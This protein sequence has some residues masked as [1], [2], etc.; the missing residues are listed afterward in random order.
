MNKEADQKHNSILVSIIVPAYNTAEYIHRAIESSLRQT[1]KNVEIVIVDDGSTDDT[2]KIVQEYT[3]RDN[4]VRVFT[5][6]NGGVSSARNHGIREAKGEF[7]IFLDSDDWLEDDAAEILAVAQL[8][9]PDMLI[10]CNLY[11]LHFVDNDS[12]HKDIFLRTKYYS[13]P[14]ME[15][16]VSETI[17]A[18]NISIHVASYAKL[19]RADV[20]RR[21]NLRFYEGIHYG[22]DQL[23]TFEYLIKMKGSF[24]VDKPLFD[25][26]YRPGSS[27]HVAHPKQLKTNSKDWVSFL[28]D[29]PEIP[30]DA[31]EA[32]AAYAAS[33]YMFRYKSALEGSSDVNNILSSRKTARKYLKYCLSRR[34]KSIPKKIYTVLTTYMPIPL[35]RGIL[36]LVRSIKRYRY[37]KNMNKPTKIREVIPYW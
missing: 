6:K 2:L 3:A 13:T 18:Y 23:F 21:Y 4:R 35:A 32:A 1:H 31:R 27:T 16:T 12:S 17:D 37:R 26:L 8:E 7:L 36:R 25:T 22:E 30:P 24:Y 9:H 10:S 14:P 33:M 20:I 28:V 5:Q 11:D 34:V 29:N 15:R 19:F